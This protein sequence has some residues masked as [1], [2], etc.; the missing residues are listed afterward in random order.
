[1]QTLSRTK[2][3]Q[4]AA[5]AVA[6]HISSVETTAGVT[7][8]G[9]LMQALQEVLHKNARLLHEHAD[10]PYPASRPDAPTR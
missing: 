1:M 8:D 9:A 3:T 5:H 4:A 6:R 7:G 2:A 10:I